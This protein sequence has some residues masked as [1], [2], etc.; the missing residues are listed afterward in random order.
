MTC[1]RASWLLYLKAVARPSTRVCTSPQNQSPAQSFLPFALELLEGDSE[2]LRADFLSKW[3][4]LASLQRTAAATI[5]RFFY[6]RN[7]RRM[8]RIEL[9][10]AKLRTTKPLTTDEAVI[11]PS[12]LVL[13]TLAAQLRALLPFFQPSMTKFFDPP[14]TSILTLSSSA[15]CPGRARRWPHGCLP[16]SEATAAAL[17]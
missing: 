8:D 7:Y 6:A 10:L 11:V 14:L 9:L 4:D 1:S 2:P 5:R 12:A 15:A 16:H 13:R 17:R 3:P